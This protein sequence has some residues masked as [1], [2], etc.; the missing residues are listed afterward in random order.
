MENQDTT[1]VIIHESSLAEVKG[2]YKGG[3]VGCGE[4]LRLK[5]GEGVLW[6]GG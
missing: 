2:G 4:S 1:L 3:S 6:E 5:G